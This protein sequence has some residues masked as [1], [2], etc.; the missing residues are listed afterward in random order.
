MCVASVCVTLAMAATS[1]AVTTWPATT[2]RTASVE[3]RIKILEETPF[4]HF[5]PSSENELIS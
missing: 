1:V 4:A 2:P 3:V 5:V